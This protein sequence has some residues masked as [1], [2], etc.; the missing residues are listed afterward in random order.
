MS[1]FYARPRSRSWLALLGIV[2]IALVLA[3]SVV[4]VAHSHP[5][6]EP[7]HDCSLC[8]TAHHV[9]QIAPS[10]QLDL[11]SLPVAVL[12]SEPALALPHRRF[13]FKLSCRP[14]PAESAFA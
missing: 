10:V 11:V 8:V 9:I 4:Q 13:F 1:V 5:S 14:P 6:G 3:S 7:D 2:C 12:T